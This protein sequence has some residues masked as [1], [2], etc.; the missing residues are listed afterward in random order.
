MIWRMPFFDLHSGLFV[1][2][3]VT[4]DPKTGEFARVEGPKGFETWQEADQAS[5]FRGDLDDE[6]SH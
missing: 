1:P 2:H 3:L 4:W 5:R 6:L